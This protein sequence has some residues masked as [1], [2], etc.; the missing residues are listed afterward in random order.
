MEAK[1]YPGVTAD[2]FARIVQNAR[3][4]T[5]LNITLTPCGE[6]SGDGIVI[7]WRFLGDNLTVQCL[8]KPWYV[9]ASAVQSKLDALVE[10]SRPDPSR[11]DPSRSVPIRPDPPRQS[12]SL[13]CGTWI[14][15]GCEREIA[16]EACCCC[17]RHCMCSKTRVTAA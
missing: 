9:P 7:S 11:P 15:T 13:R 16:C 5:G 10:Q 1:T 6:A 3:H 4:S 12:D 17:A 2:H 14:K 8:S